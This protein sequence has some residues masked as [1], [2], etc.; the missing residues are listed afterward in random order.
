VNEVPVLKRS[1]ALFFSFG[2]V[3]LLSGISYSISV[4]RPW[5]AVLFAVAAT[6]FI[7]FGFVTKAR[8]RRKQ[9]QESGN[10]PNS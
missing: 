6:G 5:L 2:G 4:G 1:L 8:A 10:Q 7:G 9:E 3:L